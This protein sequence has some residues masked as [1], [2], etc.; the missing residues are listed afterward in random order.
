MAASC[1]RDIVADNATACSMRLA[2]SPSA[3]GGGQ[4]EDVVFFS[5]RNV[6][7]RLSSH[8]VGSDEGDED[9]GPTRWRQTME[10][11]GGRADRN[12]LRQD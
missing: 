10:R 2:A 12:G 9:S 4:E 11:G 8:G 3:N 1:L 6:L 7:E 5:C